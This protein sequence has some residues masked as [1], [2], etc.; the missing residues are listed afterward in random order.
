M[1][2]SFKELI[3]FGEI[4]DDISPEDYYEAMHNMREFDEVVLDTDTYF[5]KVV[6]VLESNK[7]SASLNIV[8]N[9]YQSFEN[10]DMKDLERE[11]HTNQR[12]RDVTI[13]LG[14]AELDSFGFGESCYDV[15][16]V[17]WLPE[18][19]RRLARALYSLP[20]LSSLRLD[21]SRA[22][23]CADDMVPF[24]HLVGRFPKALKKLQLDDY[25]LQEGALDKL[26]ET[27]KGHPNMEH[28]I[29]HLST[30]TGSKEQSVQTL[31]ATLET[32]PRLKEV[33]I[34]DTTIGFSS[35]GSLS[36]RPMELCKFLETNPNLESVQLWLD[37]HKTKKHAWTKESLELVAQALRA[38]SIRLETLRVGVDS[39]MAN[40]M[41]GVGALNAK[42]IEDDET[43]RTEEDWSG[44]LSL[45]AQLAVQALD[46][47]NRRLSCHS[48]CE[49][50]TTPQHELV[51][52]L[53]STNRTLGDLYV[54]GLPLPAKLP[55]YL[56]LN[57]AG[58]AQLLQSSNPEDWMK[59]IVQHRNNLDCTLELLRL[60]PLVVDLTLRAEEEEEVTQQTQTSLVPK[61]S[62][63][64]PATKKKKNGLMKRLRR[65][66]FSR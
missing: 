13:R 31:F 43:D 56:A 17:D 10:F 29:L 26:R 16:D 54:F 39:S 38:P 28:V 15:P 45:D 34:S 27:L 14:S 4:P 44:E 2:S 8:V 22:G 1:V 62:T 36:C 37:Y 20:H 40:R 47:D 58:R 60:N 64:E 50:A 23:C 21:F 6:H 51:S 53:E 66:L 41:D 24:Y 61:T 12:I 49:T 30:N 46:Q 65:R 42:A 48:Y 18:Q 52:V 32:L 33:E 63:K 9:P 11:C 19:V 7:E 5:S 35:C 25:P 3:N 59:Q 55:V 57:K